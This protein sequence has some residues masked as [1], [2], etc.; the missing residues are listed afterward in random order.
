MYT[1]HF[2]RILSTELY[3]R[4]G[5]ADAVEMLHRNLG[6]KCPKNPFER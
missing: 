4:F 1:R 6:K 5:G 2:E 3:I